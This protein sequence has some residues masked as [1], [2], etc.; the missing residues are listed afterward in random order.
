MAPAQTRPNLPNVECVLK[1]VS[2][3]QYNKQLL[4]LLNY[5]VSNVNII[6]RI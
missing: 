2:L 1:E 5:D 6:F 4:L 3:N